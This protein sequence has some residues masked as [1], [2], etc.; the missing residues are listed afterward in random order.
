[1]SLCEADQQGQL[2]RRGHVSG[3]G[4]YE[5]PDSEVIERACRRRFTKEDKVRLLPRG[6]AV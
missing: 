1:M 3:V 6:G 4:Q 5:L 2:E